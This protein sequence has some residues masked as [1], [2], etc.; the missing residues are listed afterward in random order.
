MLAKGEVLG[1]GKR[2]V[3]IKLNEKVY[4]VGYGAYLVWMAFKEDSTPEE[5]VAQA[6]ALTGM[7]REE[8]EQLLLPFIENMERIGLI[9][10]E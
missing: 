8:A 9:S 7:K 2:G 3:L 6:I 10:R 5:V 1:K 4:E